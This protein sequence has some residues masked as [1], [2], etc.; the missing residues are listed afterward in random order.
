MS[1][2]VEIPGKFGF[3]TMS[4]TWKPTPPS[5]DQSIQT[6]DFVTS[7]PE[8]ATKLLNGGEFYGPDDLNLKLLQQFLAQSS[9]NLNKELVISIKGAFDLNKMQPDGSKEYIAKS[10]KNVASYFPKAEGRPTLIYEAARVDPK[11]PYEDTISYIKE[12][13]DDG[14]IDGISLSEVGVNSIQKALKVAPISCVE[15]ELSLFSQEVIDTGILAE[16]SKHQI[17]LIAYSPL[18][19][20]I[21]TDSA[22][23][24]AE[25]FL[26]GVND[27]RS[28]LDKFQPDI[29]KHNFPALK[30]LYDFAHDVKKTTLESLALF[31]ILKISGQKNFRGIE[32]VTRVLPIPSGSTK[33]RVQANFGSIVELT[34]DDLVAIDKIFKE[35]PIKGLRY[36][37]QVEGTLFG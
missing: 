9:P 34:D 26:D 35:H 23:E 5:F 19:R 11:V 30:A 13:V 6:L 16:L 10:V 24:N 8:F 32:Q 12:F 1:K 15:L 36:N 22:V 21:L 2:P 3:G 18:C 14:T 4:M 29:F 7:H 37:A 31:W 20:G 33:Q 17:P 27:F 25:S 28:H